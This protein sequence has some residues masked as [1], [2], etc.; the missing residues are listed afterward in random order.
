MKALLVLAALV[1]GCAGTGAAPQRSCPP[2][3]ELPANPTAAQRAVHT[4]VLVRL[5]VQCAGG[6]SEQ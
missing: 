6:D 5:Y 1:A 3:P 2:L 4:A